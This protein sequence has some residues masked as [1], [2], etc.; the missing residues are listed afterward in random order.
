MSDATHTTF[1]NW[2]AGPLNFSS[3]LLHWELLFIFHLSLRQET[4]VSSVSTEHRGLNVQYSQTLH[5]RQT[6]VNKK[7]WTP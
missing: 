5:N 3:V 2:A 7:M 6:V 1:T 4:N